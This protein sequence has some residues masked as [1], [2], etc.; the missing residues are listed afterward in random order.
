MNRESFLETVKQQYSE[1]IH[2]AFIEC[3]HGGE[4]KVDLPKLDDLLERLGQNAQKEGLSAGD[5]VEL[6]QSTLPFV[7]DQLS[8]S[9]PREALP[10]RKAA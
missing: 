6:V 7:W 2:E 9:R 4:R 8:L 10:L 1:E 3:E 5:F